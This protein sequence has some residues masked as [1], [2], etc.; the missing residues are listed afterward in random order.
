[1]PGTFVIRTLVSA[2]D[3]S[4]HDVRP[5]ALFRVY[6]TLEHGRWVLANALPRTTRAWSRE[7]LG[8]VTFVFPP[9][10][11]FARRRARATAAWVD[12]LAGAFDLPRPAPITYY[13]TDDLGETMRALGLEFFP[14]GSEPVGGRSNVAARH[15]YAG[16]ADAEGYR[17][18]LA[19]IVLAPEVSH[20]TARLV[21][22]GLMTWT[23]GS[24]GLDYA[25]LLPGL[26]R[27]LA[28]HPDLTL[29]SLLEDPPPRV[30]TL[31]VGYGGLAMLCKLLFDR[32]GLPGLRAL[33]SAGRDPGTIVSTAAGAL[34]ITPAELDSLWRRQSG[35]R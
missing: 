15:A 9:G 23:G 27:Y 35:A 6:A 14:L 34:G 21:S 28:D 18:E 32:R 17:H 4:T 25:A 33:M 7:T 16:L 3:D 26:A 24:A 29:L 30:G 5:L 11:R 12:S 13:F 31:D 2:V 1:L 22:E 10:H 8:S 19:H 20:G